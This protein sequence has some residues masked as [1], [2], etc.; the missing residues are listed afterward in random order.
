[1]TLPGAFLVEVGQGKTWFS[2][3]F[4][5]AGPDAKML[6][7]GIRFAEHLHDTDGTVYGRNI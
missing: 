1:V 6:A 5:Q 7:A 4:A 2:A 3:T